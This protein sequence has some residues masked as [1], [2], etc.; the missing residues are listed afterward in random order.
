MTKMTDGPQEHLL[1]S[2]KLIDI[3]DIVDVFDAKFY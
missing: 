1:V 2:F 3:D